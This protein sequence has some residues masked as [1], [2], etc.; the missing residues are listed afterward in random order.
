[1]S[2][3]IIVDINSNLNDLI[4][5]I[6]GFVSLIPYGTDHDDFNCFIRLYLYGVKSILESENV[7]LFDCCNSVIYDRSPAVLEDDGRK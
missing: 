6:D 7:K 4:M 2:K 1:M 3:D 5:S